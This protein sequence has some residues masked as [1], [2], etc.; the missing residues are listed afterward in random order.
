MEINPK[1]PG[2][3][4]LDK[5]DFSQLSLLCKEKKGGYNWKL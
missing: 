1:W 2:F 4:K 3:A 5:D